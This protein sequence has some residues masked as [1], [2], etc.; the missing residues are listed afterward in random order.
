[1]PNNEFILLKHAKTRINSKIPVS[2]WKLDSSGL[3]KLHG[4]LKNTDFSNIDIVIASSEYKAKKTAEIFSRKFGLEIQSY[5]E[6][7]ELNR[8]QGDFLATKSYNDLVKTAMK[9]TK[10]SANNWETADSA[11]SRFSKCIESINED[12]NDKCI[13]IVSHGIVI[14]LFLASIRKK[15]KNIYDYWKSMDFCDYAIIKNSRIIKD[16]SIKK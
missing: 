14:N 5:R 13:L 6:L 2:E 10:K 4:L 3:T 15:R 1:M 8:D 11:L 12:N 7:K 9:K 16:I